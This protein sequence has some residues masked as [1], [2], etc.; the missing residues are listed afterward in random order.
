MKEKITGTLYN[1]ECTYVVAQIMQRMLC[2][3][4]DI[5]KQD[6]CPFIRNGTKVKLDY[7]KFIPGMR[8]HQCSSQDHTVSVIQTLSRLWRRVVDGLFSISREHPPP[9]RIS[10]PLRGM[11]QPS[12]VSP[13]MHAFHRV[14]DQF[15][16]TTH[17]A[18]D[19]SRNPKPLLLSISCS[20]FCI[21]TF[22]HK[23]DIRCQSVSKVSQGR[24]K[25]LQTDVF[26]HIEL[27]R[28]K[29]DSHNIKIESP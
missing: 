3:L 18:A 28:C 25:L 29:V 16:A 4:Y 11:V 26:N 15:W 10:R 24:L 7:N 6:Y 5:S 9:L 27:W 8:V 19:M 22:L 2:T 13:Y 17:K 20:R 14:R 1:I 23:F 12:M 21:V